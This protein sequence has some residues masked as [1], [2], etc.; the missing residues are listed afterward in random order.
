MNRWADRWLEGVNQLL[1]WINEGKLKYQETV[2]DG[3]ENMPQAL[4]GML[5]G[6][7]TGKAV[8]KV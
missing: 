5:R 8:V 7:N 4:I 6:D 1:Q 2:T 3:F